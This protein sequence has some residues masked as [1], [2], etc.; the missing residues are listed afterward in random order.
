MYSLETSIDITNTPVDM[1]KLPSQENL[2]KSVYDHYNKRY[3][4]AT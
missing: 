1:N 4:E 3:E 2:F